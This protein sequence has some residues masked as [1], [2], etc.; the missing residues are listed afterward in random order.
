[1]DDKSEEQA[2]LIA[3]EQDV[4][5]A[6]EILNKDDTPYN[7]RMFVRTFYSFIEG[8]LSFFRSM[9][10]KDAS[11]RP[12]A[13][14]YDEVTLLTEESCFVDD[15]GNVVTQQ[16]Y[17]NFKGA[18][19]LSIQYFFAEALRSSKVDYGDGGWEA[20]LRGLK[21]RNRVAHPKLSAHLAITDDELETVRNAKKWADNLIHTLF[22]EK[23]RL[24]KE[25]FELLQEKIRVAEEE[26]ERARGGSES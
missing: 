12:V 24:V 25:K 9:V 10:L 19:R 7:R 16:K 14:T 26:S 4:E 3:I 20:M 1:M 13:L 22:Q 6:L 21:I 18:F 23:T 5:T 17:L 2:F 11:T 8:T 15:R